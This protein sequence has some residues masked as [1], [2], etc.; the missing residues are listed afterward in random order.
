MSRCLVFVF[1]GIIHPPLVLVIVSTLALAVGLYGND[2]SHDGAAPLLATP[3][4]LDAR[5]AEATRILKQE[6]RDAAGDE[7]AIQLFAEVVHT[8]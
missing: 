1:N 7:E 4:K 3:A 2:L 6:R 5:N 8:E